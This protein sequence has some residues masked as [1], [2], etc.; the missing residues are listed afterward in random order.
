MSDRWRWTEACDSQPCPGDCDFCSFDPEG[1]DKAPELEEWI[2]KLSTPSN[3]GIVQ[4]IFLAKDAP[5]EEVFVGLDAQ[6]KVIKRFVE[7]NLDLCREK[8]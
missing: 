6:L 7:H 3:R 4:P 5:L 8:R 1:D 2:L